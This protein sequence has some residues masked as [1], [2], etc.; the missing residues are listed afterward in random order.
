MNLF[1]QNVPDVDDDDGLGYEAD[2]RNVA[3]EMFASGNVLL[4]VHWDNPLYN[5]K[6]DAVA[7]QGHA[8]AGQHQVENDDT[9]QGV[10]YEADK[11]ENYDSVNDMT[12]EANQIENCNTASEP[13]SF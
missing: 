2:D 7:D 5:R 9:V 1:F 13:H 12:N 8:Q 4:Q 3:G 11:V 10:K 6:G